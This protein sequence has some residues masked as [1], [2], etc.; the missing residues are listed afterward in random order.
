MELIQIETSYL[1]YVI[2]C[3]LSDNF[4]ENLAFMV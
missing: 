1:L 2:V 4:Q 3:F